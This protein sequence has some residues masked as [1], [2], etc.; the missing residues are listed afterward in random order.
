VLTDEAMI[1]EQY[2]FGREESPVGGCN[3]KLV[4]LFRLGSDYYRIIRN[5]FNHLWCGT[6]PFLSIRSLEDVAKEI[7]EAVRGYMGCTPKKKDFSSR[8]NKNK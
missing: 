6:N 1:I 7:S 5:T 2:H 4:P 8:Q 3:G